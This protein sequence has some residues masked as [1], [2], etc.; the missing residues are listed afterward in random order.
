MEVLRS[1]IVKTRKDHQCHGCLTNIPK[2]TNV[3]SQ[4]NVSDGIYTLYMCDECN[5]WCSDRKCMDCLDMEEAYRGY[6]KECR[7]EWPVTP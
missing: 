2:G 6:I 5:K 3:Y 4:T 1:G 7:R